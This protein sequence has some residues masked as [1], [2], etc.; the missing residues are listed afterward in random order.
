MPTRGARVI[1]RCFALSSLSYVAHLVHRALYRGFILKSL[2]PSYA[3]L[4]GVV[5]TI[6]R[7]PG[8]LHRVLHERSSKSLSREQT[9]RHKML[10][11]SQ[12]LP[13]I[14]CKSM[15]VEND[16]DGHTKMAPNMFE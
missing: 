10:V 12:L 15:G 4:P 16:Q 2:V 13:V 3:T 9:V 7:P 5:W 8:V 1:I 11:P 14:Q 6:V